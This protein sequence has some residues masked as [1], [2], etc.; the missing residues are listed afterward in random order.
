[1]KKLFLL[2]FLFCAILQAQNNIDLS[3]YLPQ[4][5]TYNKA[6]PNPES[7]IGHQ[8]GEWHVTHDKLVQYA[9][10]LANASDRITIED[11]GRTFEDR[12]ILL[13]TITSP[14]NHQRIDDIRKAHIDATNSN[15]N[16]K[17]SNMPIVV[18]Q[19]FSIHGNEASGANAGLLAAYYLAAAQGDAINELLNNTVILFDP[20]FNPD[21]LQRFAYWANTNKSINLN[22][23]PNDREYSEVWPGGRTNHYWFDMNRDWLPVQLPESRARIA[24][25]HKW[26]P[27]ILT[28]H[29]EMGTN[30]TFFFQPGIPSRTHPLTPKLNQKLTR[31]IGNYHAKAFN[32]IG[33][34]Y[35]TEESFD[36]FYYGKGSTFPDINGGIGILF[37]QGSTRGHIQESDNGILTFPFAIR[38]QFTAALSTL[39]AAKNMR[40]EI[41]TYQHNFFKN[42]RREAAKENGKG[43]VFGD[44]KDA[45]KTYHL[46]EILNRHKIKFNEVKQ[47]F[48]ANGKRFKKGHSY[49]IPK[50]QKNTRLINAMF[51]KRTT[52]QDSLFYDISAWTFPLAFNLDYAEGVSTSNAGSEVTDL[53]FKSGIV[54][55]QSNYAYLM[56]WHEYYTPKVLNKLLNKNIRAKVA[57]KQFSLNGK[58]YDY[59]TILIQ[60]QNQNM[61]SQELHALLKHLAREGHVQIDAVSTGLTQGIDLGSNHFRALQKPKIA[62][63]VGDGIS[64]YDAGEIWHLFDTRYDITV[65]K[66]DTKT[67]GRADLSRYNTI[68]MPNARSLSESNTKKIKTW[69]ENGGTII[70]YR[71]TVKW[72]NTKELA[73]LEFKKVEVPAK[74]VTFEERRDFRGAQVIGGA[75]FEA[76]IDRSHP[77]NFGYKNNKIALFRNTTIFMKPDKNSYNNPIQYTK[78]PILAGYI[79][80]PNLDSIG[81]TVPLQIKP[82]GKGKVVAFTDNTNFRAFWY[83]TNK[84]LMNAIFFREEL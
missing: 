2:S 41:L 74:N 78:R 18:Y 69:V 24:T 67:I 40:E 5:V 84:L 72:F 51:E 56:E 20:S 42:A 54:S 27:N 52:F 38:N 57:M 79:S 31:E 66:L 35:Y 55:G 8:V 19:G 39:D 70:G 7:V 75:I 13:L 30:S 71:N 59:G 83:G 25:F 63:L 46:A 76:E 36:D 58:K 15:S 61:L 11:R 6:I 68:I 49:I 43:I 77:I 3:Y 64:S 29:H 21:G 14:K 22:P 12:P 62:L 53:Q 1:M 34:L 4:S 65:T 33:S 10:A 17:V 45:A 81:S 80:K 60:V 37:E 50:N 28:D 16:T 23:D 48:T 82:L 47:D 73:K 44:E 26:L 32:K 9:Y